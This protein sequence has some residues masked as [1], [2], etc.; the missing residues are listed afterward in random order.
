MEFDQFFTGDAQKLT[1]EIWCNNYKACNHVLQWMF[2]PGKVAFGAVYTAL[3]QP[4][5]TH[6][7]IEQFYFSEL[8]L[9]HHH[10]SVKSRGFGVELAEIPVSEHAGKC[11]CPDGHVGMGID[12][13]AVVFH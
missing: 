11:G 5:G 4:V 12:G 6:Y 10:I 7:F 13:A 9:V 8:G 1:P 2:A 3:M